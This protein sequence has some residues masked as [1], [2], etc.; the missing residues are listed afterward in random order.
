MTTA[1]LIP[2]ILNILP[3]S[4]YPKMSRIYA[5]LNI[6]CMMHLETGRN[7]AIK[8]QIRNLMGSANSIADPEFSVSIIR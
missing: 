8:K 6:A 5:S 2:T 7:F 4:S 3:L 1:S